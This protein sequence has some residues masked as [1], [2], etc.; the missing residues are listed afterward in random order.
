MVES[1]WPS[2]QGRTRNH[3][4]LSRSWTYKRMSWVISRLGWGVQLRGRRPIRRSWKN[5]WGGSFVPSKPY[6]VLLSAAP[7]PDVMMWY[8]VDVLMAYLKVSRHAYEEWS[9]HE[10]ERG[11]PRWPESPTRSSLL[12]EESASGEPTNIFWLRLCIMQGSAGLQEYP[13][14]PR[15]LLRWRQRSEQVCDILW[16]LII[17]LEEDSGVRGWCRVPRKMTYIILPRA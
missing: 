6:R 4:W 3:C 15:Q 8:L 9:I 10:R 7:I 1:N 16:F 13:H 17:L 14:N 12:C 5:L 2:E 11:H